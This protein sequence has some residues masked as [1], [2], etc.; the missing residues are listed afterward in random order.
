M[1]FDSLLFAIKGND[2]HKIQEWEEMSI[3]VGKKGREKESVA[4][5]TTERREDD[6]QSERIPTDTWCFWRHY[7]AIPMK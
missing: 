2:A 5:E 4:A 1:S 3:H 6:Q 7:P